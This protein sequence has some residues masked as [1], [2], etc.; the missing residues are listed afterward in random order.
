LSASGVAPNLA[1]RAAYVHEAGRLRVHGRR[2]ES[3]HECRR[4]LQNKVRDRLRHGEST[5]HLREYLAELQSTGFD[6]R[7]IENVASTEPT[8]KPWQVGEVLAEVL[9]EDTEN[10]TF[11]WPPS[12]DK[13]T[14][15]ASLPGPDIIGFH[16]AQDRE[17][18][19]FGEIKSS[20]AKDLHASVIYGDDG[21]RNQ[22]DRLLASEER[23][24][25]LIAW[26]KVRAPGQAWKARFD[27]CLA[28]YFA[29]TAEALIVGVL[30]SGLPP[31]ESHLAPVR[32]AVE[33]SGTDFQVLLLGYYLPIPLADWPQALA[34]TLDR[35]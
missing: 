29:E 8:P 10:A 25:V 12:W 31:D 4:Y 2:T 13:R 17:H 9:L 6:V 30:L 33:A 26:L 14:A 32:T 22:I 20:D 23:R 28:A 7:N 21:L 5:T 24:H 19:L 3:T 1:W 15:S 27:F 18:F 11:P 16:A 35:P 34:G